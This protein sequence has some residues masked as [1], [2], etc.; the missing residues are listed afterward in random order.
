MTGHIWVTADVLAVKGSGRV[1]GTFC[2]YIRR[3]ALL[4][5][6]FSKYRK[7]IFMGVTPKGLRSTIVP[8]GAVEARTVVAA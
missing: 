6:K 5:G 2:F 3:R 7:G 8:S 4:G 1:F